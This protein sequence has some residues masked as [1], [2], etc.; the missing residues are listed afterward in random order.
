MYEKGKRIRLHRK[1]KKNWLW[2][3]K[4]VFSNAEA[5]IDIILTVNFMDGVAKIR[6]QKYICKRGEALLTLDEWAEGWRWHR[7]KVRRF[8]D[9]LKDAGMISVEHDASKLRIRVLNYDKMQ[10][11][12]EAGTDAMYEFDGFINVYEKIMDNWIWEKH[13]KFSR[14]E[15]WLYLLLKAT[16]YEWCKLS[17]RLAY[18]RNRSR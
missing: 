18:S 1:F 2:T 11:N 12:P 13:R 10:A 5:W 6:N 14:A 3:E 17:L 4:R 16:L 9:K 15:A 7:S 8:L